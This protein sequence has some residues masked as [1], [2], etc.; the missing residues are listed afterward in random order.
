MNKM[1]KKAA[2]VV[3][4]LNSEGKKIYKT[5]SFNKDE[6]QIKESPFWC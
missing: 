6:K 5:S 1:E 3:F 4:P 2:V